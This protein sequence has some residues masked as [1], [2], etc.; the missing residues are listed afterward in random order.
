MYVGW[1]VLH[2]RRLLLIAR[3]CGKVRGADGVSTRTFPQFAAGQKTGRSSPTGS[4]PPYSGAT[5][6]AATAA[7]SSPIRRNAAAI[8]GGRARGRAVLDLERDRAPVGERNRVAGLG[9][10]LADGAGDGAQQRGLVP[11][12]ARREL[13]VRHDSVDDPPPERALVGD[14]QRPERPGQTDQRVENNGAPQPST[15]TLAIGSPVS[16]ANVWAIATWTGCFGSR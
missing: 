16:S 14:D 12:R 1:R 8:T 3:N 7:E 5:P 2:R 13:R 9:A 6:V 10:R 4:P 15:P 11:G